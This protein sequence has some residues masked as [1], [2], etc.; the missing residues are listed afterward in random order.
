MATATAAEA[1]TAGAATAGGGN[2]GGGGGAG[3]PVGYSGVDERRIHCR[4]KPAPVPGYEGLRQYRTSPPF[5]ARFFSNKKAVF[6]GKHTDKVVAARMYDVGCLRMAGKVIRAMNFPPSDYVPDLTAIMHLPELTH[7]N[8]REHASNQVHSLIETLALAAH[9][10]HP[11]AT[12]PTGGNFTPANF[13]AVT[14]SPAGGLALRATYRSSSLAII[15]SDSKGEGGSLP[16]EVRQIDTQEGAP[17]DLQDAPEAREP[18]AQGKEPAT[19]MQ[20]DA[21]SALAPAL[22]GEGLLAYLHRH[23]YKQFCEQDALYL[24]GAIPVCN[25]AEWRPPSIEPDVIRSGLETWR[26]GLLASDTDSCR[27]GRSCFVEGVQAALQS[28]FVAGDLHPGT[29]TPVAGA[30]HAGDSERTATLLTLMWVLD[31]ALKSASDADTPV[32][33][34][35]APSPHPGTLPHATA[36]QTTEHRLLVFRAAREAATVPECGLHLLL[37]TLEYILLAVTELV[38]TDSSSVYYK[39]DWLEWLL[40]FARMLSKPYCELLK[41]FVRSGPLA[42]TDAF[43]SRKKLRNVLIACLAIDPIMRE[44]GGPMISLLPRLVKEW[45]KLW[46][47]IRNTVR[48]ELRQA[49]VPLTPE[50]SNLF[51]VAS[52]DRMP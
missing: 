2:E 50:I 45:V 34:A 17:H 32:P 16:P 37:R 8:T 33:G 38:A 43:E 12:T 19:G 48:A 25:D 44:D 21:G 13:T 4:K 5:R 9:V 29:G 41:H 10:R 30:T 3:A 24:S 26:H 31:D 47:P 1:A 42:S 52:T 14:Q 51:L 15:K 39:A 6:L 35:L 11:G 40:D 36:E 49:E 22:A 18:F 20:G 23:A 27:K 7:E 46:E 28:S